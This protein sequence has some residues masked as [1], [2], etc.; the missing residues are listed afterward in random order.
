MSSTLDDFSQFG[1]S[2]EEKDK[3]VAELIRYV[4]FKT[5]QNN[6]CPIKR[7]ELTQIITDKKYKQRNLPNFIIN[8][9]K[10]K[11]STIFG[12]DMRELQRSRPSSATASSQQSDAKSYVLISKL[13][14]DVYQKFV[15]NH[16][17]VHLTGF[18]FVVLG[19]VHLA[20]GKI[21]EENLWHHFRRLGLSDTEDSHPVLGNTKQALEALVQQRY[22]QK[23]KVNGTEGNTLYYEFAERA[24]DEAVSRKIKDYV[25]QMVQK[26]VSPTDGDDADD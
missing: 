8:E 14:A 25:S 19:I 16:D 26:D 11:L 17:T 18:T 3:L 10:S 2:H 12:Y 1:I 22:L 6:G 15:E 24:Q 21:T 7:E 9:V 20:G 13:P 4:L 5:E 23:D